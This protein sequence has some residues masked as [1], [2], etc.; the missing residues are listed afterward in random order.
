MPLLK[1][2]ARGEHVLPGKVD[3]T[4]AKGAA[5]LTPPGA[6]APSQ[7]PLERS[8]GGDPPCQPGP[9]PPPPPLIEGRPLLARWKVTMKGPGS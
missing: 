1:H 3:V 4:P 5:A 2:L 6:S 8:R 7:V 9:P